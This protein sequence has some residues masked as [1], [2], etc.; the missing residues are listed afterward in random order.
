MKVNYG[1]RGPSVESYL[2]YY[3]F[4]RD[5]VHLQFPVALTET[6]SAAY[7]CRRYKYY[8]TKIKYYCIQSQDAQ[9][10]AAMSTKAVKPGETPRKFWSQ[11]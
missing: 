3:S 1:R 5:K 7:D 4:N 11:H 10:A 9:S 2:L 8:Y 6:M